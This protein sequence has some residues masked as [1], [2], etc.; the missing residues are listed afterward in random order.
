SSCPKACLYVIP[1]DDNSRRSSERAKDSAG[2]PIDSSASAKDFAR[3]LK[4]SKDF[5]FA[6]RAQQRTDRNGEHR[7]TSRKSAKPQRI[8]VVRIIKCGATNPPLLASN[9]LNSAS[10]GFVS[11]RAIRGQTFL[12]KKAHE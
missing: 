5:T 7:Q 8:A 9:L 2:I 12:S 3:I 10:S 6:R 11:I 1:Q 4:D